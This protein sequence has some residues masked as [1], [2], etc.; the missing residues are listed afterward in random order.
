MAF[1]A[2]AH[3]ATAAIGDY[4]PK[5]HAIQSEHGPR[6]HDQQHVE[7]GLD[8]T[9]FRVV[10]VQFNINEDRTHARDVQGARRKCQRH[11]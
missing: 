11:M 3:G 4:D 2:L 5:P 1:D 6:L 9:Q 7:R 8:T 10:D